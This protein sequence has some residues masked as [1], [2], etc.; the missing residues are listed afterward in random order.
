MTSA[1][2]FL[3]A[4]RLGRRHGRPLEHE[5]ARHVVA[6]MDAAFVTSG[7]G[8]PSPAGCGAAAV[9]RHRLGLKAG[10]PRDIREIRQRLVTDSYFD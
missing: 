4:F 9:D 8:G 2:P 3:G 7:G 1:P 5:P 6:G 10:A